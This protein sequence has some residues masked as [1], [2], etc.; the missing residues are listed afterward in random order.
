PA[1]AAVP[2][3]WLRLVR[4]AALGL[5]AAHEAGLCHGHLQGGHLLLTADGTLKVNGLGEPPWL[6]NTVAG[7]LERGT[8]TLGAEP[9]GDLAALG[10]IAATLGA[11]GT[12]GRGN[13][14]KGPQKAMQA[15]LQ[16]LQ[17]EAGDNRYSST[18]AL[19]EDVDRCCADVPPNPEGWDR[20]LA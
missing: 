19:L 12:A 4:Q 5:N 8:P 11:P 13:K 2:G 6:S 14:V 3:I 18:A 16:R 10:R 1:L 9:A 7:E 17:A 20:L 15:I